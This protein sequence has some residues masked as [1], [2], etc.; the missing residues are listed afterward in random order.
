MTESASGLKIK[1]M[2]MWTFR[3]LFSFSFLLSTT[4]LSAQAESSPLVYWVGFTDKA[5]TPYT[6]DSPEVFLSSRAIERRR[7]FAISITEED[8]PVNPAHTAGI[9][10]TGAVV[11]YTSRWLNGAVVI[12]DDVQ[13]GQIRELPYADT[14]YYISKYQEATPAKE[15]T[16]DDSDIYQS[17]PDKEYGYSTPYLRMLNGDSLHAQGFRGEGMY[18]AV[19]D[20]GFINIDK[21]PVFDSLRQ[22]QSF[23]DFYDFADADSSV[24]E[25]STHGSSV[26]SAMAAYA[27]GIMIG[28]APMARYLCLKTEEV[29]GEYRLEEFN[30]VAGIEYADRLG[31]D[32]VNAS[33]GYYHFSDP[34]M[35][36]RP[37]QLDGKHSPASRAAEI[38][39]S[40]GMIVVVSAGNEGNSRWK[41][42]DV[43]ADAPSAL[44]I[45]AV[46]ADGQRAGFSSIGREESEVIKPDLA[47]PGV[48]VAVPNAYRNRM[49]AA[50]GTS[51]AAPLFAGMVT[52]LWQAFPE[53]SNA[54]IVAA[55]KASASQSQR[56]DRLLGYGIPDFMQAFRYLSVRQT[57]AKTE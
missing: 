10:S 55:V 23:T 6:V 19:L 52:C 9:G 3:L 32:V 41:Y 15:Y 27:P 13:L 48:F 40:R 17:S 39:F 57:D 45:A 4:V 1:I 46:M 30:W 38:A 25:S 35:N 24:L 2:H 16:Y 18:I 44:S 51:L 42:I 50:S 34:E 33:L 56:P 12:A 28:T 22:R 36:Y 26:L 37:D 29:R 49:S 47:A 7:R 43:P 20:G 8:L 21:E 11:K 5:G 14:V 54:E 31:V 53:R